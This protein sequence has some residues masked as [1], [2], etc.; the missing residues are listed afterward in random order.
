MR[1][2]IDPSI[3]YGRA[4]ASRY[5]PHICWLDGFSIEE[6]IVLRAPAQAPTTIDSARSARATYMMAVL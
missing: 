2:A 5:Q 3:G 1:T 4:C 6:D